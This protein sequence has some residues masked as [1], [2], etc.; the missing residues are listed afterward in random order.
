MSKLFLSFSLFFSRSNDCG[1]LLLQR[2]AL[3]CIYKIGEVPCGL[4][5]TSDIPLRF[6][7]LGLGIFGFVF[8]E[9]LIF[10]R[11]GMR[12]NIDMSMAMYIE[13]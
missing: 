6:F 7:V 4:H 1:V 5:Y 11:F 3:T 2:R 13:A 9:F 10:G 8:F 12:E